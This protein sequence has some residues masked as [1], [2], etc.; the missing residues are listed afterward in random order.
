ME[1]DN[2]RPHILVVGL[3]N[4]LLQ[5]DGIGVHAVRALQQETPP[6]V[7]VA[8]VGCAVLDALH[9]FEWADKIIAI[10]AMQAGGEPG[11]VYTYRE[12]DIAD[13]PMPVSL[14]EV[15]IKAAFRFLDKP[16][17]AEVVFIGVEPAVINYGLELTP[18]VEAALP[19]VLKAVRDM[20]D[21]WC[22][23]ACQVLVGAAS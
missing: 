3:G 5:D 2:E 1:L 12:D 6:G 7:C 18:A 15:S 13:N 10:D 16:V 9:L 19:T 17:E 14:H 20:I 22:E 11:T 8:D 4:L 23:Q 21:A